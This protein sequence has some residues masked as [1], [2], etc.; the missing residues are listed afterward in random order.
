MQ[1]VINNNGSK[2]LEAAKRKAE[3]AIANLKKIE[4]E[5]KAKAAAKAAR[6][7]EE[8]R[9]KATRQKFLLGALMLSE[10]EA[11]AACRDNVMDRLSVYLVK[12]RDRAL[13]DLPAIEPAPVVSPAP[14]QS[15]KS[16]ASPASLDDVLAAVG[17]T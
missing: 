15:P 8:A 4:A 17:N 6:E 2:K 5:E 13:F 9:K 11:N 10:M 14:I 3:E 1:A 7:A 12:D 16:V